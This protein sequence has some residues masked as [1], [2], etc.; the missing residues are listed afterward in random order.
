MRCEMSQ[1]SSQTDSALAKLEK[2]IE[3]HRLTETKTIN[4][5]RKIRKNMM[6]K[7]VSRLPQIQ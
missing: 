4:R 3:A 6:N 5:I 1:Q 2:D 7:N